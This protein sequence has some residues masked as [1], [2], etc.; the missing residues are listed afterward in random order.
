KRIR[1]KG[2]K[3]IKQGNYQRKPLHT[4]SEPL[5]EEV[6]VVV[7]Q[8]T[9]VPRDNENRFRALSNNTDLNQ[10]FC[11]RE[12]RQI[13]NDLTI[14][15]FQKKTTIGCRKHYDLLSKPEVCRR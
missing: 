9:V 8:C 11:Y 2:L 12:Q 1:C 6:M 14:N 15:S 3:G 5:K 7:K 13:R 4:K 10:I